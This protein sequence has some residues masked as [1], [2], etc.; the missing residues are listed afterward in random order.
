[1]RLKNALV[2]TALVG[3]VMLFAPLAADA[4]H[5]G[6]G[7]GSQGGHAVARPLAGRPQAARPP[8]RRTSVGVGMYWGAPYYGYG[9]LW[10]GYPRWWYPFGYGAYWYGPYWYGPYGYGRYNYEVGSLKFDVKPKN[11]EVFVDGYYA[12]TASE[13]GGIFASLDVDAGN[14]SVALWNQGYRT[15]TQDVLVQRGKQFKMTYQMVRLAGG[16]PQDPRPIPPPESL[17]PRERRDAP[18]PPDQPAPPNRP[19]RPR[20]PAPPPPPAPAQPAPPSAPVASGEASDYSQLTIRVQPAGA[21]VLI[22]GEAW[23]GS[24]TTDRLVV[25]LPVGVHHVEVRK[26]GFKTFKTDVQ[27]RP[28]E[29]TTLNVSLSGQGG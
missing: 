25:H 4:Q 9:G 7:G 29:T 21:Q 22:D 18:P 14:H 6:A 12:G 27:L 24:Q 5:R 16:E 13:F 20:Q 8:A 17:E 3:G 11:T 23:Q 19:R 1:M 2:A 28:A 10:W 26:D 15:V